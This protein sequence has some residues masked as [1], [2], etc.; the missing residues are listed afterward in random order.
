ML[1]PDILRDSQRYLRHYYCEP[2]RTC[3]MVFFE[4]RQKVGD[5]GTIIVAHKLYKEGKWG[6]PKSYDYESLIKCAELWREK[7][8]ETLETS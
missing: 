2:N 4:F 5:N 3:L 6:S 1:D 8:N 7:R